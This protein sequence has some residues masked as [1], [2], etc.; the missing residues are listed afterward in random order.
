V[1]DRAALTGIV[2]VLRTGISWP[3][4]PAE[5]GCSSGVTC[6]RRLRDWQAAG[7][8]A[9][10]HQVLLARLA[11][12]QRLDWKRASVDSR[13]LAAKRGGIHGLAGASTSHDVGWCTSTLQHLRATGGR[14]RT[15]IFRALG[16]PAPRACGAGLPRSSEAP[17]AVHH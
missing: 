16:E 7:V 3:L 9:Q 15:L 12:A 4:L 6:W 10:V 5:L 2:F 14:E 8:W 17:E 1:D 13:S 11:H